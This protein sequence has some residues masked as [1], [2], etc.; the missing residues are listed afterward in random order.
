LDNQNLLFSR[1]IQKSQ[2]LSF[3]TDIPKKWVVDC[4]FVGA[5]DKALI[6]LGGTCIVA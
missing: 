2:N 4:Q 1:E 3:P 6:Y 5:G